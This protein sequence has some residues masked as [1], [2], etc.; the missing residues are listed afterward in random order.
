MKVTTVAPTGSIAK[1]PGATE[2]IHPIYARHFIRRVRFSMPDPAQAKTVN[3]AMLAG[4]AVEMHQAE[5]A[6]NAV[7]FTANVPEGLDLDSTMDVIKSWLPD[8]KGHHNHGRR[9]ARA[10]AVR[11]D[12]RGAVQL[13]HCDLDRGLDG[14]GLYDRRL[15]RA[16]V[17]TQTPPAA[18][19]QGA[20]LHLRPCSRR[21]ALPG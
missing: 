20:C 8:L 10:G 12:H 3:D 18:S 5:Y 6:D 19:R 9:H 21:P 1:L 17:K 4:Y 16:V 14:R 2:G 11:A 7:S 13:L 15:P